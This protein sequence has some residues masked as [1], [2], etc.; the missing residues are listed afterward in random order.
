VYPCKE[1]CPVAAPA[2]NS[3]CATPP[4]GTCAYTFGPTCSFSCLCWSGQW[5]CYGTP[6][7]DPPTGSG[8]DGGT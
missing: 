6:C 4:T 2:I 7:T 1:D 8:L 3:P 5:T